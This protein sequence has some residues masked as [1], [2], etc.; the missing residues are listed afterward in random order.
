VE[1]Y[2]TSGGGVGCNGH[3][4]RNERF[5]ADQKIRYAYASYKFLYTLSRTARYQCA[6]L[7]Q[8]A[9]EKVAKPHL[10]AVKKQVEH[11]LASSA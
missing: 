2:F 3:P 8:N 10:A 6:G 1:A 4:E 9:Y 11:A 5:K 7:P